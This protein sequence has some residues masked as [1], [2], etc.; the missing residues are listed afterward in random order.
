MKKIEFII[1]RMEQVW[2]TCF[3][4]LKNIQTSIVVWEKITYVVPYMV[5]EK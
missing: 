5:V 3:N 2:I 1:E 4:Y